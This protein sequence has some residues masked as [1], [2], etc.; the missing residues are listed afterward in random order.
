MGL[1]LFP[2]PDPSSKLEDPAWQGWL[3]T[4]YRLFGPGD[5]GIFTVAL[6]PAAPNPGQKAFASNGRKVGESAG[7]GTGVPVY[8]S[9]GWRVYSTDAVVTT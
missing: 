1:R 6:L 5:L 9:N 4:L 2:P 3:Q 8:Y 7:N